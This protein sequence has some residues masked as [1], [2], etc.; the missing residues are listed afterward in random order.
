MPYPHPIPKRGELALTMTT[1]VTTGTRLIPDLRP[2]ERLV[3]LQRQHP[4]V[5]F[6]R[7]LKPL[8][9]LALWAA[10]LIF[11]LPFIS[12]LQADPLTAVAPQGLPSWLPAVLWLGWL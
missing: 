1:G 8:L 6:R 4:A 12:S 11:V 2:G 9:L 3:L 10:S 5:L 7:L